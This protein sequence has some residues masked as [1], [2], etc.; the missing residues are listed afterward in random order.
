MIVVGPS[1]QADINN[2]YSVEV[3]SYKDGHRCYWV[4]EAKLT[5]LLAAAWFLVG[6][7]VGILVV[8]GAVLKVY[9]RELDAHFWA[10][11]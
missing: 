1:S 2:I 6:I 11:F 7:A 10:C 5:P 9:I 4:N 8:A 3:D